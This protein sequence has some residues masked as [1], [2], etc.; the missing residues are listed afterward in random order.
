MAKKGISKEHRKFIQLVADGSEQG[1]AYKVTVGSSTV[2]TLVCNSKG[3]VL[4]SKYSNEIAEQ[5]KLNK[6]IVDKANEKIVSKFANIEILSKADR[7]KFLSG[8]VTSEK[9]T[10]YTTDKIRSV[11][12]LNKMDGSYAPEK[13]QDVT[14]KLTEEERTLRVNVLLEKAKKK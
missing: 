13:H 7:M 8:V 3:S 5:V 2:T 6:S 4:A 9:D 11:A 14:P 12:E 1:A 10:I